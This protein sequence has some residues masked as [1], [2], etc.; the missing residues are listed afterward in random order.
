MPIMKLM[1]KWIAS[2][3]GYGNIHRQM[4]S[5]QFQTKLLVGELQKSRDEIAFRKEALE[6]TET[7]FREELDRN[8]QALAT[9]EATGKK[10]EMALHASQEALK[11][12]NEITIPGLI[13]VNETFRTAWDAEAAAFVMRRVASNPRESEA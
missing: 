13:Q 9:A 10:L 7:W 6:R 4:V 12:T 5:L 2:W 11:I 8:L 3:F 1:G